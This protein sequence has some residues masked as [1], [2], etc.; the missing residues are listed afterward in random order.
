MPDQELTELFELIKGAD[1][2]EL[3]L[4]VP[5][6]DRSKAGAALGVDPLDG[7][8]RQVYFFDTPDLALNKSGVVV[9]A[10]RVQ[11]RG[12]DSV[13]K[14]R[15]VVPD[16]L[17]AELRLSENFGVEVDAMP[18]GFVCSGSMKHAMGTT[19]VRD[20]VAG[21]LPL[22]KLFSKEQR[23]LYTA[24]APEGLALD[25]LSILGPVLV[26]K[27]KFAPEGYDRKLVAELWLYP[28]NSMLLELSTK[29]APSEAFEIAVET[30][31]FLTQHGIDLSGEQETKTKKA[32]EFFSRQQWQRWSRA[33]SWRR[34]TTDSGSKQNSRSPIVRGIDAAV[35][36]AEVL[37]RFVFGAGETIAGTVYGTIVVLAVLAA[38]G[39]PFENDLW[40]LV[41]IVVT[42][43]LVL[44]MSH[45]YAH[46]LAESV[47][48]GRRLDV[49]EFA[50]IAQREL[51]MPL[52][53][54]APTAM[55]VL[56]AVG[57][58]GGRTAVLLALG[59]GVA[60][61]AVQGLRYARV[62]HFGRVGTL[63]AVALNTALG[64]TLVVLEVLV[65]H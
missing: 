29:C 62:E 45:V 35:S 16:E 49:A 31:I 52:V 33:R 8:I 14:L 23:A 53:A 6:S 4:S 40:R 30:R 54:V 64:L 28:D 43:V 15:P 60:I 1:S 21:K 13:V 18:G 36:R 34:V 11:Q 47:K 56:G 50:A 44:W 58:F 9:R 41:A 25:D 63:A 48:A 22:R 39:K 59:V 20:A 12:N 51:A 38:G 10:R 19:D 26:L 17:P 57:L 7:Q 27:L 46:G 3:K 61:L 65:S 42:T 37:A 24:H 2:V 32:L 5:L 55:L